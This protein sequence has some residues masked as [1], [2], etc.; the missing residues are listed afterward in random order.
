MQHLDLRTLRAVV[1]VYLEVLRLACLG[2]LTAYLKMK[3]LVPSSVEGLSPEICPGPVHRRR[4]RE[5]LVA[6]ESKKAKQNFA[7]SRQLNMA[8]TE[9]APTSAPSTQTPVHTCY[10]VSGS[11]PAASKNRQT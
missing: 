4:G 11:Q 10:V 2:S 1:A 3:N 5:G 9:S 6:I 8:H 7:A